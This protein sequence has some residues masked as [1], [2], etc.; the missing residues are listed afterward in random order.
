M[1]IVFDALTA[2][3]WAIQAD[4]LHRLA[5]FAQRGG[6]NKEAAEAARLLREQELAMVAGSTARRLEGARYAMVSQ[7]GVAVLPVFGPIFPRANLMTEMSGASSA[8]ALLNDYRLALS[9][10][11][12][13]AVML[14]MDTPGGAVSGINALHD[15]IAAGRKQKPTMTYVTGTA[16]SA[17]YW[18]AAAV[19]PGN[20]AMERTGVVGSIGVVAAI[21]KQVEPGSD[22][23]VAVEIVSANA[24]NKRPDPTTAEGADTIRATLN[25]IE[26][27]FIADVAKGRGVPVETVKA[28]FGQGG[29]MVG[30]DAVTAGMAD[31]I[32][33]YDAAFAELATMVRNKRRA[34][35]L[36]K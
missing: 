19:G 8:G 9:N 25:A 7:D 32:M 5:A 34:D 3:P 30:K 27:Q 18:I 17:G 28:D 11:D 23:V 13:G 29:V 35:A 26:T 31:K 33:S 15:A 20:I 12:I 14:L 1:T 24:P 6:L 4:W 2:E 21:P 22:G 10:A 36:R 16:A